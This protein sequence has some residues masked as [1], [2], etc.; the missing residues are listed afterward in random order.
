LANGNVTP[1]RIIEGQNTNL[2]RTM[3]G[4]AYDEINDEIVVPVALSGAVL[5]FR[6]S[7]T[8]DEPPI[9][10]IQG[11]RTGM[12][13]PQTVEVDPISNEIVAADS[14]SRA[15]LVYDRLA[16]GDV[17]PKRKIG[18]SKTMF[19]DIIGIA[20]DTKSNLIVAAS[21]ST[22]GFSGILMFDRMASGD[23]APVRKI[24]GP[25]TGAN[26]RFRQLKIDSER[27]L[28]YLAVQSTRPTAKTPQKAADLYTNE[29][30]LKRLRE[31]A[32]QADDENRSPGVDP[33]TTAGFI[34]V[35]S[36]NDDGNVPPRMIIRGPAVGTTGFAGVAFN[37]RHSE[38]YGVSG[39]LN[40]YIAWTVPEFFRK[41]GDR[42]TAG[43]Q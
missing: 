4:L 34:G 40:G 9:R 17:E 42:I 12:I 5:V 7:A 32:S 11:A 36:L 22:D 15:I 28:V 21:R 33:L 1:D 30:S 8:G 43:Q 31:I 2:S 16:N 37:T 41:P 39:S 18:G 14:S 10:V 26:G 19:R 25:L 6:G 23:V 3:H 27:G 13:R 35:W 20:I 29:A 24:G 38:V